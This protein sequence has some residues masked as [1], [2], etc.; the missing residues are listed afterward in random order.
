MAQIFNR[1]LCVILLAFLLFGVVLGQI[2]T[3][4]EE[5]KANPG[6]WIDNNVT[7][8]GIVDIYVPATSS[9][10]SYYL[11]KGDYGEIIKVNTTK[12]PPELNK[13]HRV[14]GPVY[15]DPVT[16]EA[17]ISEQER[18]NLEEVVPPPPPEPDNTLIYILSGAL[19]VLVGLFLFMQIRNSNK[20]RDHIE[21]YHPSS[22]S[23]DHPGS[24]PDSPVSYQ[25]DFKT[26][27]IVNPSAKTMKFIPGELVIVSGDDKGKSF[28]IAG[29]PTPNGT[30]V[31][32]GREAVTGERAYAHIQID[33]KFSTVSRKQAEILYRDGRLSVRNL[34]ETNYTKVDGADLKPGDVAELRPNSI[35]K[36]GEL[37]F[38][39]RV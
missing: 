5:I 24:I 14:S 19:V 16:K 30:T 11:V 22:A 7:V 28:K 23:Q 3:S 4:I 15:V 18:V 37:E 9:T 33:D 39:Y 12:G 26:V 29:F 2:K 27:K 17:F 38:Q 32:I 10:T 34:S 31:T 36:A 1:I 21:E 6:Q 13:R 20:N 8:E 25:S 35:V